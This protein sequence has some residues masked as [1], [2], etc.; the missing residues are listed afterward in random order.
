MVAGTTP[1]QLKFMV[2][3]PQPMHQRA[4]SMFISTE[5]S[6]FWHPFIL[7]LLYSPKCCYRNLRH[8]LKVTSNVTFWVSSSPWN[9]FMCTF[10]EILILFR[11]YILIHFELSHFCHQT[12][13]SPRAGTTLFSGLVFSLVTSTMSSAYSR[14]PWKAHPQLYRVCQHQLSSFFF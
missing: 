14:R 2:T 9:L 8:L 13:R 1:G 10:L 11:L 12:V 6:T 7:E 4:H 5:L 3:L